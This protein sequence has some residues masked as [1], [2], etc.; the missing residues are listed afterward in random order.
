MFFI[1]YMFVGVCLSGLFVYT[2]KHIINNF[3]VSHLKNVGEMFSGTVSFK[4]SK[5]D[6]IFC[7]ILPFDLPSYGDLERR[8][9]KYNTNVSSFW[10]GLV[11]K[12]L[13]LFYSKKGSRIMNS[14][15]TPED[16][17]FLE[18][19]YQIVL[20]KINNSEEIFQ[21]KIKLHSTSKD[22]FGR[23]YALKYKGFDSNFGWHY[24]ALGPDEYRTIFTVRQQ[25]DRRACLAY[26]DVN[27][28]TVFMKI[29]V[30]KGVLI[31]SGE[32][33]HAVLQDKECIYADGKELERWV[34][35]FT[36]TTIKNDTR[37]FIGAVD[38]FF[39]EK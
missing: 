35:I 14:D 8:M 26:K 27:Q 20:E 19:I 36:Y 24:D 5:N 32:T 21:K 28:N 3:D 12:S 17:S 33:F 10:H 7:E 30:G 29:A 34:V 37:R 9:D 16:K 15:W 18:E 25:G 22:Y 38:K 13:G 31:R 1:Q 6:N 11:S 39:R 23:L 4:P 2:Y